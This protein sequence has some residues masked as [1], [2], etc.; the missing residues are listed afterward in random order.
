M[1]TIATLGAGSERY[2]MRSSFD[3]IDEYYVRGEERGH[4]TGRGAEALGL[5]GEVTAEALTAVLDGRAPADGGSLVARSL[6]KRRAGFDFTFSAPKGV[7][8]IGLLGDAATSAQVLAGHQSAVAQALGY[9]ERH[10][11][12][13]R[14]G[15]GGARFEPA[16][17]LVGAAFVHV[18]SRAGD[19][20]LHTHLL[21]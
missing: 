8:L 11:T 5:S 20:Q 10:A 19:P 3:A 17:G 13:V 21:T 15:H 16:E 6:G 18:T 12:F 4:W 2:Y 1:L 14:R 9:L 7:S